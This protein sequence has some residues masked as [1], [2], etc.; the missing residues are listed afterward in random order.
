MVHGGPPKG[1]RRAS[2]ASPPN[3]D[4]GGSGDDRLLVFAWTHRIGFEY[5]VAGNPF[6]R[7]LKYRLRVGLEHDAFPGTPTARVHS[8]MEALREFAT[9]IMGVEFGT[10]IDIA[11]GAAQRAE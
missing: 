1:A 4:C 3:S 2:P 6:E 7:L 9:I 10:N 8:R 5:V 11:L